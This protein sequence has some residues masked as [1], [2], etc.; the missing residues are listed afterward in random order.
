MI[1]KTLTEVFKND[2][3]HVDMKTA[4]GILLL[5]GYLAGYEKG[6]V[7]HQADRSGLRL[8]IKKLKEEIFTL[9]DHIKNLNTLIKAQ[10]SWEKTGD[11]HGV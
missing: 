1:R 4:H 3:P 8:E 6:R 11:E 7:K 9:N 5:Q 10:D 2:F